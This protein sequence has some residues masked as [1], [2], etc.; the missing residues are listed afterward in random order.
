[1]SGHDDGVRT[2]SDGSRGGGAPPLYVLRVVKGPDNGRTLMLDWN[3]LPQVTVGQSPMCELTLADSRVSR[4]HLTLAPDGP[5]VRFTDLGSTNG[6]RIGGA[7]VVEALLDGGE[8]LELGESALRIVRAGSLATTPGPERDRF[9]RVLGRSHEMQRVFGLAERLS[10]SQLPLL[11]EGETGTGKALLAEAIHDASPRRGAP[12]VF[13]DCG[14]LGGDDE[15]VALFGR[16]GPGAIDAAGA[17]TLVLDEVGDLSPAAQ[18][19][20]AAALARTTARVIAT[21]RRDLERDVQEGGF[22]EDLLFRVAGARIALPPLRQRHGDVELLARHF[23]SLFGGLGDPPKTFL[24]R[25]ARYP[26]PGNVRE[27]EHAVGRRVALG[28]D[29]DAAIPTG[30]GEG[31]AGD[32]LAR[33]LSMDLP[34]AR[35]RQMVVEEFERRY[36]ERALEAHGGNVS[37]AAAASG[38]T[39]RYFHM[40]RARQR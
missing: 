11:V 1:M 27:L 10:A 6:T 19:R 16:G 37:R 25:L 40:L 38:L 23:W 26:W 18:T 12:F 30:D 2:E 34:M 13:F 21:T 20:L 4:R 24:L 5:S 8:T 7:R 36:V 35:A 29:Q 3:T 32:V 14:A 9:G 15:I 39:R 28:D 33:V 22:R 31:G 17:G